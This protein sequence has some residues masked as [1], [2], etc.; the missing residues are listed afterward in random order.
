MYFEIYGCVWNNSLHIW[1][2]RFILEVR[3]Q[4]IE[5]CTPKYI[6]LFFAFCFCLTWG[7]LWHIRAIRRYDMIFH[8]Q[9][10]YI[11]NCFLPFQ[12]TWVH[13]WFL[14]WVRVAR[15]LVF[16]V[17]FC[18]SL[19]LLVFLSFISWPLYC[20]LF[21]LWL[22]LHLWYIQTFLIAKDKWVWQRF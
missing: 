13:P 3:T 1:I 2:Q 11:C 18:R 8:N 9:N 6:C 4:K 12:S 21:D 5:E 14:L 22:W 20:L 19:I 16:C 10:A 7:F 17:V 15:S